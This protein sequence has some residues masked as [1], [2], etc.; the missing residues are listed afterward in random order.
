MKT[1]ISVPD[2]LFERADLVARRLGMSRS[3]L[4]SRALEEFL[5]PPTDE[6]IT[7]RLDRVYEQD[8]ARLEPPFRD[9]QRRAVGE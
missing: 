6:E 2:A 1:A 4:Y 8:D 9:A 7:A 5:G 3:E